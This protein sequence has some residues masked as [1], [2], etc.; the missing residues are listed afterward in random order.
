MVTAG[1]VGAIAGAV[2]VLAH[3]SLLP[4][5]PCGRRAMEAGSL[6][7]PEHSIV[8]EHSNIHALRLEVPQRNGDALHAVV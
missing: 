8:T 3:K 2:V 1:A 5:I 7:T 4:P 6:F